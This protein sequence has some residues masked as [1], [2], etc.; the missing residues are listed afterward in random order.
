MPINLLQRQQRT[1]EVGRIRLGMKAPVAGKPG[2]TRPAKLAV[3]RFTSRD[4]HAIRAV[5]ELYGGTARKWEDAPTDD[6]WEVI[7]EAR[8]IGII[9]PP[10][11]FSVSQWM[12]MWS[13]GG[14]VR[15][16]DGDTEHLRR[17]P[18]LCPS[19]PDEMRAAVEAGEACRPTTRLSVVLP[20][21]P[22]LGVWRLESHGWNAAHELGTT[23]EFLSRLM[24][25]KTYV[26][27]VMRLEKRRTVS[28][29]KTKEYV[30]PVITLR[31][32]VRAMLEGPPSGRIELPPPPPRALA[33]EAAK[34]DAPA[35]A[36][37]APPGPEGPIPAGIP[38]TAQ[39]MAALAVVCTD[40]RRLDELGRDARR[41]EWMDDYVL[42]R[43]APNP[44]EAIELV[45]VF[46]NRAAEL[47]V[48]R[49]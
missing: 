25:A 29:G 5:A 31:E 35:T 45:E 27:A 6:Q 43:Y 10:G 20:D 17:Q 39:E 30:V 3:L 33:L 37:A 41:Q 18:C 1:Y 2:K 4:E 26:P 32:T 21:V 14:C 23:A 34:P 24:E 16:C 48:D 44:D 19:D 15:R 46:R 38:S 12:E 9:V 47:E 22:G 40:R 11:P 36:E 7:T 8:E 42:S 13:G 28:R 49:G